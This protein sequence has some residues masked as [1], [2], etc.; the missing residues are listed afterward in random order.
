MKTL[1]LLRHGHAES[2]QNH[3]DVT[4]NLDETGKKEALLTGEKL[5]KEGLRPEHIIS[6]HA[7]R[8]YQTAQIVAETLAYPVKNILIEREIY[9]N[10]EESLLEV[11]KRQDNK[12]A[13]VLV[14]GHNPTI[15][16]L[17]KMLAKEQQHDMPTAGVLVLQCEANSW[18]EI[19]NHPIKEMLF[20]KPDIAL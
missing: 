13:S 18:E 4:R 17:A 12:T 9:D 10:D 11:I 19:L 3:P 15:T 7:T 16:Y 6:S 1:Y 2:K 14:A 20:F 8:A 5:V